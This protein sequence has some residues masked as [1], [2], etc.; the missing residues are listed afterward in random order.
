MEWG[1]GDGKKDAIS[2][3]PLPIPH[4]PFPISYSPLGE[5]GV[6]AV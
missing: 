4:S 2:Y 6:L 1:I 5:L 3:S